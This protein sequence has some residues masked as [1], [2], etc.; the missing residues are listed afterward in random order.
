MYAALIIWETFILLFYLLTNALDFYFARI[1]I[2]MVIS[3]K[4][5]PTGAM[6]IM[7]WRFG[8]Y[9]IRLNIGRSILF[10]SKLKFLWSHYL[11][12]WNCSLFLVALHIEF[13]YFV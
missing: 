5:S 12:T 10:Q 8:S 3:L 1:D 4:Q 11:N 6:F 13:K 7:K 9:E 2:Y